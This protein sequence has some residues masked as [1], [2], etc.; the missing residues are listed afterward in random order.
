MKLCLE[1]DFPPPLFSTMAGRVACIG[2]TM[3]SGDKIF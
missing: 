2:K 1:Y 3:I